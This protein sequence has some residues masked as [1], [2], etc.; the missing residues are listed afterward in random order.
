MTLGE[1]RQ[2]TKDLPDEVLLSYHSYVKGCSLSSYRLED[3]WTF[4][5]DGPPKAFV[6]NPGE[7]YDPRRP[8]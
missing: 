7:N 4:P 2:A 6:I 8:K 3:A 5:V 1:F